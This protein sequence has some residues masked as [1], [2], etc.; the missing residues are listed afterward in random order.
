MQKHEKGT[1]RS[2]LCCCTCG[3]QLA[4]L[5]SISERRHSG[6]ECLELA[7]HHRSR[8]FV[9]LDVSHSYHS[10]PNEASVDLELYT[11]RSPCQLPTRPLPA[12][13]VMEPTIRG[14]ATS[15]SSP[16]IQT[17]VMCILPKGLT[18]PSQTGFPPDEVLW[19]C[20]ASWL[21]RPMLSYD[22]GCCDSVP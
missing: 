22:A 16:F 5:V 11:Q 8:L 2:R 7:V 17:P 4:Y 20:R 13:S 1:I 12:L 15:A 9:I 18:G 14:G 21:P 6:P 3:R 10:W 19:A